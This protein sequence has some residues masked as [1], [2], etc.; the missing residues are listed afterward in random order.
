MHYLFGEHPHF[1]SIFV[2]A[3]AGSFANEEKYNVKI[4]IFFPDCHAHSG[5]FIK[6]L[7]DNARKV[8]NGAPPHF[9]T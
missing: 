8:T 5:C 6:F 7:W 3:H 1:L 4:F 2:H 9:I